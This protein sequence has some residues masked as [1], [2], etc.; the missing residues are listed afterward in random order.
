MTA[1]LRPR[2]MG[3]RQLTDALLLDLAICNDGVLAALDRRISHLLTPGSSNW[4]HLEVIS[5]D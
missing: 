1:E 4:K 2:I 5:V 3:P